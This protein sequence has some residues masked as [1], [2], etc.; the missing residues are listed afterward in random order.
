MRP[1]TKFNP[2]LFN[3][4]YWHLQPLLRDNTI[5]YI[6]IE[7]G[8]SASKTHTICQ[9]I[10]LDMLRFNYST[11]VFRRFGVDI[12]DSVYE[13]FDEVIKT[14]KMDPYFNFLENRIR[15]K[16]GDATH[17]IRFRGLDKEESI[18]G[19]A[20]YNLIY[21]NEWSQFDESHFSQQRKRLRGKPNQKIICDWNPVS[22]KLWIY[23]NW[24]DEQKWYD[25]PLDEGNRKYSSLNSEFS[26]KRVNKKCNAVWMKITHRDNYWIVGHP[27]GKDGY[28]DQHTLDDYEYDKK[29]HP[30]LYRIYANGERGV[31]RTGTE[32]WK[33][34][35]EVYHVKPVK[36]DKNRTIHAVLDENRRPYVTIAI[37]QDFDGELTQVAEIPCKYPNNTSTKAAAELVKWLDKLEYEDVVFLWGDKS[38]RNKSTVD[39]NGLSFFDKFQGVILDAGYHV[40]DRVCRSAPEIALSADFVNDIYEGNIPGISIVI[41]DKCKTSIDDYIMVKEDADGRMV[42][43]KVK[44]EED[45]VPVELYGHFSDCK[46]YFITEYKKAEFQFYKQRKR[47]NRSR[48]AKRVL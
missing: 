44:S 28:V 38:I 48:T 46:R 18:K 26:F 27:N 35:N 29:H 39:E 14:L 13:T 21:N 34:F 22:D 24:I 33:S 11:L 19:I 20:K 47:R 6:F 7:G 15:M 25:L 23:Q 5:R 41:G 30:N 31:I 36:P 3:P 40:R 42:K 43:N 37:W 45:D 9:A 4:L 16:T 8:S 10:A 12:K 2:K 1:K 32:F 17:R